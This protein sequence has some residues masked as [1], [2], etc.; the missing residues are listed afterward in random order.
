MIALLVCAAHIHKADHTQAFKDSL[1]AE[2]AV[3]NLADILRAKCRI[4]HF[5]GVPPFIMVG[6]GQKV[7]MW[8]ALQT[9]TIF[10]CLGVAVLP[11]KQ[12]PAK[13]DY[14]IKSFVHSL[15]LR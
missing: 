7:G 11:S 2:H 9:L 8:P 1:K 4:Q 10:S 14:C 12:R 3:T 13:C 15:E 6:S 5:P